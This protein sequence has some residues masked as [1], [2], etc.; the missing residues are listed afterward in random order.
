MFNIYFLRLEN[1]VYFVRI[2][3]KE[4]ENFRNA[5][6][7]QKVKFDEWEEVTENSKHHFIN[8]QKYQ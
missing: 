6:I 2:N 1:P 8:F 3:E 7:M 4:F 5:L